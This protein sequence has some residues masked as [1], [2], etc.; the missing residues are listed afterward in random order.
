MENQVFQ[1]RPEYWQQTI[2]DSGWLQADPNQSHQWLFAPP[3][4]CPS[5]YQYL[6]KELGNVVYQ[7]QVKPRALKGKNQTPVR[8]VKNMI[9][10]SSAKGGVGKSSVTVNLA[11]ALAKNGARV[12]ILDADIYGPSIPL[13]LGVEGVQPS[14]N[15]GKTMEPLEAHGV[16]A[17]SI[18]FLQPAEEAAI[19]RGPMASKA[20]LQLLQETN[21]PNLDYLFIDMPPGT[22]DIQLTMA[23]QMPVTATAVVTTPQKLAI[24]D[25][26]KGISMFYHVNVPVL[27][28]IENMSYYMCPSCGDKHH[29]FGKDGAVMLGEATELPVLAQLPFDPSVNESNENGDNLQSADLQS[30]QLYQDLGERLVTQL[31]YNS[32]ERAES[33]AVEVI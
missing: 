9:A 32:S 20:L 24:R 7:P 21:W 30:A 13:L 3:F 25:A 12:G 1:F 27:G 31:Y 14:S 8:G 4:P 16:Y 6:E 23:Q 11:T 15:D 5:V 28:I 33:I 19:W 18:G 10:I 22:G 26:H 2:G 17:N 29:L